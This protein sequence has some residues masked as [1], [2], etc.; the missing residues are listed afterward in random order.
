MSFSFLSELLVN[1]NG[2]CH[3]NLVH[4]SYTEVSGGRHVGLIVR[5]VL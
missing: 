5:V 2:N 4:A 1:D 3:Y